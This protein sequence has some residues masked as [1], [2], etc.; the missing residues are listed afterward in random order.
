MLPVAATWKSLG[1]RLGYRHQYSPNLGA[2]GNRA[3]VYEFTRVHN[4]LGAFD[5]LIKDN[6]VFKVGVVRTIKHP[7][8]L[9]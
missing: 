4:E 2:N 1:R 3:R 7:A 9:A 5:T 8:R 6:L